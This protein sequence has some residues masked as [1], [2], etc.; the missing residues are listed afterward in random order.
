MFN[1]GTVKAE[2]LMSLHGSAS[3]LHLSFAACPN[4]R[5]FLSWFIY[6]LYFMKT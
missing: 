5:V 4:I 1:L 2:A 3:D 6:V